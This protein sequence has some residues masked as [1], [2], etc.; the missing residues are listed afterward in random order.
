[1]ATI[2]PSI[3]LKGIEGYRVKVEVQL[4]PG[5]E[6]VNIVGLP[7]TSVK[8]SK[9]RV[10]AA[11]YAN[12][13]QIPDKK[14]VINLSPAELKKNSP[15]FDLAMAIGV[16]KGAGD[17]KDPIPDD[18]AFLGVLSLDGSIRPVD[19]MLP[20]IV[21]TKKEDMK[22]SYLPPINDFPLDHIHGIELRFVETLH[23]VIESF[24][25]QLTTF[26]IASPTAST[27][28]EDF[29][30]SYDKDF[31]HV[32]GVIGVSPPPRSKNGFCPQYWPLV[33]LHPQFVHLFHHTLMHLPLNY[34]L[35]WVVLF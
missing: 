26:S 22:I 4:V 29:I 25:G 23:E 32:L 35:F 31:Q 34:L 1:M 6:G 2:I 13:C 19:G 14:V 20:A 17:I 30:P 33:H 7:D 12:D 24:S 8:E 10:M 28:I 18:A 5:V 9:D 15:I 27:M 21:A 11:L 3:G 16:M